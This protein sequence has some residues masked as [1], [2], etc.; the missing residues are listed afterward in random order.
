MADGRRVALVT[1]VGRRRGIGA[2]IALGLAEQDTGW[3]NEQQLAEQAHRVPLG[4]VGQPD[5]CANLVRFLCSPQ[6]GWIN[7]Q[8]LHS[9]GGV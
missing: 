7:G 6:G 8:L 1:G 9:N 3:M 4:R 2:A 5:D